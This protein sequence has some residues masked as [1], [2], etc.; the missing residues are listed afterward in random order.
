MNRDKKIKKFVPNAWLV[1]GNK[2]KMQKQRTLSQNAALHKWFEIIE[3]EAQ[4]E[5][6]SLDMLVKNP[7]EIPI[8]KH[9]LKD[10]FRLTGKTMYGKDSTAKLTKQEMSKVIDVFQKVVS[11]RLGIYIEFPSIEALMNK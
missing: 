9:L 10:L 8:T 6:A 4:N 1:G 7:M 2:Y 11:E 5:G 3:Q